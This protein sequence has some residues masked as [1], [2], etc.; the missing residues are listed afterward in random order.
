MTVE[1]IIAIIAAAVVSALGWL[2]SAKDAAQERQISALWT[3]HDEDAA[4]LGELQRQVDKDYYV[5]RELDNRFDRL[6]MTFRTGIDKLSDQFANLAN[7]LT[8]H[9]S[10][11]DAR[12]DARDKRERAR[13]NEE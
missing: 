2:L 4:K 1:A 13:R 6:E 10:R 12:E 3:K 9:I 5:K 7:V 8:D 11:E